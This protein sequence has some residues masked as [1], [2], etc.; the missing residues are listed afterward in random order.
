MEMII[1]IVFPLSVHTTQTLTDYTEFV[2]QAYERHVKNHPGY[3][4]QHRIQIFDL[5]FI[6]YGRYHQI[7]G[8]NKYGYRNDYGDLQKIKRTPIRFTCV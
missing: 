4:K 2:S 7:N 3:H 5:R 1:I 8:N 6:D